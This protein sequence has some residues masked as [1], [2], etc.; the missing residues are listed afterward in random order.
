MET[1]KQIFADM[2][3]FLKENIEVRKEPEYWSEIVRQ[4]SELEKKYNGNQFA[5][6]MLYACTKRLCEL[7]DKG[8]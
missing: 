5:K 1:E 2:F 6:D 8:V 4:Q 7:C 3:N